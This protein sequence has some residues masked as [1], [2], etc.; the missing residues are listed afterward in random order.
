MH[1]INRPPQGLVATRKGN[2]HKGLSQTPSMGSLLWAVPQVSVDA[3]NEVPACEW[4]VVVGLSH[5]QRQ[6]YCITS[7]QAV[8]NRLYFSGLLTAPHQ[9]AGPHDRCRKG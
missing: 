7:R 3:I 1:S 9:V 8:A 6:V 5:L 2:N 4:F